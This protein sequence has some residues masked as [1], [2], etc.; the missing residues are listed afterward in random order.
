VMLTA[1]L[2]VAW[3]FF[4]LIAAAVVF[5]GLPEAN[6]LNRLG[7]NLAAFWASMAV[8]RIRSP[9]S[10]IVLCFFGAVLLRTFLDF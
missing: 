7:A 6:R 1:E 5:V 10:G 4:L 9:A 8:R 2:V 3:V